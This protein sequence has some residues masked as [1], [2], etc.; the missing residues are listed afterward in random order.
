M[1]VSNVDISVEKWVPFD[2]KRKFPIVFY[3]F[4]DNIRRSNSILQ[5]SSKS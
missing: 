2:E 5:I 4:S 3:L 1:I